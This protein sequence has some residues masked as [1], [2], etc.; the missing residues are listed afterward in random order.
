MGQCLTIVED[1]QVPYCVQSLLATLQ[2]QWEL[3][4]LCH[5][6]KNN[7]LIIFATVYYSLLGR[8]LCMGALLVC[9]INCPPNS[10]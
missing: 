6:T 8:H 1:Q 4:R 3:S 10:N 7:H 9:S 2:C 5:V